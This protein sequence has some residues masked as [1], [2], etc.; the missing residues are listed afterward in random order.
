MAE[1]VH[2][3]V[4][5]AGYWGAKLIYEYIQ[6]SKQN[7]NVKLVAVVD[8]SKE[9]LRKIATMYNLP[10]SMLHK[11]PEEIAKNSD[12]NAVHIA[13]PNETHYQL[14]A[15]MLEHDKHVLLEK[16]M[17]L[18]S[19]EAFKLARL[20]ETTGKVLLVG[21][22]F[23]FNNALKHLRERL[24][25]TDPQEVYYID[26]IWA[27]HLNP[28]PPNRDIIFDLAPHPVDII[29]YLLEEWPTEVYTIAQTPIRR[30]KG[31][32]EVAHTLLRLPHDITASIKLSWIEHG[33]KKRHVQLVT[34]KETIFID[35]ISQEVTV[36]NEREVH[37]IPI[38]ASNTILEMIRHFT[39]TIIRGESP[40]NSAL[41][42][43]L[44]VVVLEA[45]RKSLE[46]N[47]P[48]KLPI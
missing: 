33:P 16:P 14:A 42:G 25:N 39:D 34:S 29:N 10:N 22:I 23:R 2:V 27:A 32:E 20:A 12:I 43:A 28:P 11:E 38:K 18:S 44:T 17:A 41:V 37:Q 30:R 5:G 45:M 31:L 9:R 46:E 7:P 15:L 24:R 48:V 1:K 19:R 3:A 47:K 6:L 13:T 36:Y 8:K 21:H 4:I 35:T 40:N 26:L